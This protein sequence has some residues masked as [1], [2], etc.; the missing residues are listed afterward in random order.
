MAAAWVVK[1]VSMKAVERVVAM[2]E[3]RAE[4]KA[5]C[6]AAQTVVD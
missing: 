5:A 4:M 2:D 6:W 1:K 3:K